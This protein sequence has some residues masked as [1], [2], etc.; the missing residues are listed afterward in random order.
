LKLW[1]LTLTA[2]VFFGVF[3]SSSPGMDHCSISI[4]EL[5]L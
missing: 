1:W 3:G 2:L 4:W 5:V